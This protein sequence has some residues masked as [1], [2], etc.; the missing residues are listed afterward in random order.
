LPTC[1]GKARCARHCPQ[2]DRSSESRAAGGAIA[3]PAP[4][5]AGAEADSENDSDAIQA[6]FGSNGS[7]FGRGW[8]HRPKLHWI[9]SRVN[10]L[11]LPSRKGNV[12]SN[13]H[14]Y[15]LAIMEYDL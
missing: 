14:Q 6:S 7:P 11:S 3:S 4:S 2:V 13:P 12:I 1:T 10:A 8:S 15:R 5:D 9:R